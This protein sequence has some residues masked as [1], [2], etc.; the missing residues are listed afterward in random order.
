MI[1]LFA[2][3][4]PGVAR[5]SLPAAASDVQA[6]GVGGGAPFGGLG[7][8]AEAGESRTEPNSVAM[9]NRRDVRRI[10]ISSGCWCIHAIVGLRK[11]PLRPEPSRVF[12]RAWGFTDFCAGNDSSASGEFRYAVFDT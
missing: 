10:A 6:T 8:A 7:G 3:L 9:A 5:R 12:E 11:M 1:W 4:T 2:D